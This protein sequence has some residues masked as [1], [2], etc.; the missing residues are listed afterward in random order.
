MTDL[1]TSSEA[2]PV[3]AAAISD[4]LASLHLPAGRLTPSELERAASEVALRPE[5]WEDLV[6]DSFDER[7]WL[8]LHNAGN[9]EVRVLS[10]EFDQ[11][12]GWHDH[13]G[14]SGGFYV[15]S[16]KLDEQS[17]A[18]SGAAVKSV[19][20]GPGE[21]GCFGPAHVHDVAYADGHPAVS[22]HAYSPP[23]RFLTMYDETPLGL[24]AREV[25]PDYRPA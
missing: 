9:Y 4:L 13:G 18:V 17:R 5:L 10:W 24:V 21:R 23:L 7:W 22:I 25:V 6:V 11:S 14:A 16:G 1:S 15:T 12:S 3:K 19:Q 20:F 2:P 8:L